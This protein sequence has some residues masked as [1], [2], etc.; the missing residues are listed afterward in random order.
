MWSRNIYER[1]MYPYALY[2]VYGAYRYISM[3]IPVTCVTIKTSNKSHY[4]EL[5]TLEYK[6]YY[7]SFHNVV[8]ISI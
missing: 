1:A 7:Q 8:I 4:L 2:C 3:Y 5:C 6:E